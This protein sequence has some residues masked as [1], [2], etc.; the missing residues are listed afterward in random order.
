MLEQQQ[1]R[2]ENYDTDNLIYI[3]T[4]VARL[5]MIRALKEAYR[6]D[7]VLAAIT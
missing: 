2:L 3:N 7:Q 6:K 5:Q 1:I 4:D